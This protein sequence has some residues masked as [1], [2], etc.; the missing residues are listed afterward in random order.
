MRES[1]EQRVEFV[2]PVEVAQT[3]RLH[4]YFQQRNRRG[5]RPSSRSL[6]PVKYRVCERGILFAFLD[7]VDEDA[8]IQAN[9]AMSA[10]KLV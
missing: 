3:I 7:V 5:H 9:L 6:K 10:Q 4:K 1:G 8:C 2:Y